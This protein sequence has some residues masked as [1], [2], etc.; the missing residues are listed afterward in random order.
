V[1]FQPPTASAEASLP[2]EI[3]INLD[4]NPALELGVRAAEALIG[5]SEELLFWYQQVVGGGGVVE[6]ASA[7]VLEGILLKQ[8][9]QRRGAAVVKGKDSKQTK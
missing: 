9:Q 1:P 7:E 5:A 4:G 2:E 3:H 6:N 8:Q